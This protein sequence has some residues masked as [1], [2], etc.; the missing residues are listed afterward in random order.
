VI[1]LFIFDWDGTLVDSAGKIVGAM[2]RAIA[3]LDLPPRSEAEVRNIIG[4]ALP[5]A[6]EHL[7]P[8]SS[9]AT[10]RAMHE[11]YVGHFLEADAAQR[12]T[13]FAGAA[14]ALEGLRQR[15]CQLAV[16]T[17]KSRRGLER[18]LLQTGWGEL[19]SASRCA[20]ETRSKPHPQML[21]ELL[22]LL[23]VAPAQ[24][25]M[26]GD[27][28]YDMAMARSAGMPRLGVSH[29]AHEAARLHPYQPLRILD[30]LDELVPWHDSRAE[31]LN[32][33]G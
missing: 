22:Q 23:R 19:F 7:F 5:E 21:H 9:A 2:Q 29:G 4:L 16:A 25:L 20:D 30:R 24:A 15:G 26:I 14:E 32:A 27:T 17:S 13:P 31:K 11:A 12:C 1:K 3:D 28:E 18:G 6:I 10:L 8:G 33:E